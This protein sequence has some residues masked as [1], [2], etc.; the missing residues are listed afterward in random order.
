[1]ITFTNI[2]KFNPSMSGWIEDPP[3]DK[4][5]PL[6]KTSLASQGDLPDYID[7]SIYFKEVSAQASYP[8]CAANAGADMWEAQSIVEKVNAGWQLDT[9]REATP[10]LSRMFLWWHA[11][12]LMYPQK[13]ADATSGTYIRLVMETIARYGVPPEAKWTYCEENAT[14]R[15]GITAQKLAVPNMCEAFYNVSE[16]DPDE[17]VNLLVKALAAKYNPSFGTVLEQQ[18]KS[19]KTGI[20]HKPTG[21][22]IGR[23]AMVMCGWSKEKQAFKVRNSWS[24]WWG[25]DGYCWMHRDYITAPATGSIWICTKGAM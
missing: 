4:D 2:P 16:R 25:E 22:I 15:P 24:P 7:N 19:Y 1:V 8:S 18:F 6:S 21:T 17:R 10:D 12:N 13:S 5:L 11:R 23:H 14:K 9:A 3:S 20:I